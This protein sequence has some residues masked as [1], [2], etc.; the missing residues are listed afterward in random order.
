LLLE[1]SYD[2]F[3]E[4]NSCRATWRTNSG[5]IGN[6]KW[7]WQ[8]DKHLSMAFLQKQPVGHFRFFRPREMTLRKLYRRSAKGLETHLGSKHLDTLHHGRCG[9][10]RGAKNLSPWSL[11][12][13][14][15]QQLAAYRCF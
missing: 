7:K 14:C 4:S 13:I 9:V 15:D 6:T 12:F 10:E 11:V 5:N 1:I 8:I 3:N 2:F